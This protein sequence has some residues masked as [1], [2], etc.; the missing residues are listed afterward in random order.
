MQLTE[1]T[2]QEDPRLRAFGYSFE[3]VSLL[4]GPMAADS[5][6]AAEDQSAKVEV[7]LFPN[8][9]HAQVFDSP[10]DSERVIQLIRSNCRI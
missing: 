7:V 8:L 3:Q 9:D 10:S 6:E 1:T 4:L 2:I 5:K